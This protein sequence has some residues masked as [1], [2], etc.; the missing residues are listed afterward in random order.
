M[1]FFKRKDDEAPKGVI[2]QVSRDYEATNKLNLDTHFSSSD[3]RPSLTNSTLSVSP[4]PPPL[5][6]RSQNNSYN[7]LPRNN[8]AP[9]PYS[10]STPAPPSL[11]GRKPS[12]SSITSAFTNLNLSSNNQPTQSTNPALQRAALNAASDP[13]VQSAAFNAA[14]D[15]ALQK[16]AYGAASSYASG[17]QSNAAM[18]SSLANNPVFQ[19]AAMNA[20]RDP[21]VQAAAADAARNP[22]V[23]QAAVAGLASAFGGTV[24]AVGKGAPP[25]PPNKKKVVVAIA[26]F[27][28]VE[29]DDLSLQVGDLVT[30]TEDIDENWY[31]GTSSRGTELPQMN[32]ADIFSLPTEIRQCILKYLP[33]DEYL[34][35]VGL[36]CKSLFASSL[37]HSIPFAQIHFAA[38][39]IR[40]D[41]DT[42]CIWNYLHNNAHQISHL[43]TTYTLVICRRALE[44]PDCPTSEHTLNLNP[45]TSFY[46]STTKI[47][48]LLLKD[49]S[50]DPS[51]HSSR[52]LNWPFM[53]K[54]VKLGKLLLT[55]PRVDATENN[56]SLFINSCKES[57]LDWVQLFLADS[58]VD[59]SFESNRPLK[60]ACSGRNID[61]VATLLKDPRVDLNNADD[62]FLFVVGG[63][64]ETIVQLFLEDKRIDPSLNNNRALK[65]A[66]RNN[67]ACVVLMLLDDARVDPNEGLREAAEFCRSD[68]VRLLLADPRVDPSINN[69]AVI[70]RA[71]LRWDY[72]DSDDGTHILRLLLSDRRV[73]PTA[74]N[75]EVLHNMLALRHSK[76]VKLLTE[77]GRVDYCP[78]DQ[79]TT[80]VIEGGFLNW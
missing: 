22:A 3:R 49:P 69:N 33:V 77:D 23:K 45:S 5:P 10:S 17:N 16:A 66:A 55:D 71:L 65:I 20:A 54:D 60:A 51:I 62:L 2:T 53:S 70:R 67:N 63:G 56:H 47:I 6:S 74:N 37:F 4:V 25:P 1:N 14:K 76:A 24:G 75:S 28:A 30:V 41:S 61:V 80:N 13:R 78:R 9:P 11:P 64:N 79:R 58:R 34:I 50:F 31:R 73:D 46:N 40:C 44:S 57:V 7:S 43:P 12:A 8:N 39:V 42:H 26:E 59:P 36:T 18:A 27:E 19:K 32:T 29:P 21:G 72:S 15:P 48:P 68:I 35:Q 38:E 52:V